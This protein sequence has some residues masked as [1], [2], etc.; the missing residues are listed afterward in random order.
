MEAEPPGGSTEAPERLSRFRYAAAAAAKGAVVGGTMLIPGVSGGTTAIIL[1]IYDQ[2]VRAVSGFRAHKRESLRLLFWFCL[3]ACGGILLL[4]RPLLGL[5]EQFPLPTGCFFLGAVAGSVPAVY[6]KSRIQ[7]FQ[8]RVPVYVL[9]GA[10][11]VLAL[12]RLPV[13][14]HEAAAGGAGGFLLLLLAG[15][16]SAAALVL[17]GISVSYLLLLLGLYDGT[18]TAIARLDLAFLFPLALG[19]LAGIFLFTRALD[20]LMTRYPRA[21][22]LVILGFMLASLPT[23]LPGLPGAAE[24]LPCLLSLLAG[25]LIIHRVSRL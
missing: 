13:P 21:T 11:L 2:L 16:L 15:A 18:M 1:G 5:L 25:F 14:A 17:P 24:W 8:W 23:L 20:L 3:G 19:L 7:H 4:A 12:N 9:L 10:A 6:R 22:Y